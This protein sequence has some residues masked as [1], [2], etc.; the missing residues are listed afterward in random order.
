M[1][2]PIFNVVGNH[3]NEEQMPIIDKV[4]SL[5]S[6]H[7]MFNVDN[8]SST[9]EDPSY[10][11]FEDLDQC[12]DKAR[13]PELHSIARFIQSQSNPHKKQKLLGKFSDLKPIVFVRFNT[14][15]TGR[16]HPVTLKALLDSGGS[17]SL[18]TQQYA[19]KLKLKKSGQASTAWIT[20]AGSLTMTT[21]CKG[22][23][24]LLELH[25]NRLIEW[26]LHVTKTWRCMT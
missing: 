21:K 22:Q 4:P 3:Y 12:I 24:T 9:S 25:D 14:K 15:Q 18:V 7:E 13:E 2:G 23:F 20:P 10:Q 8:D 17:G 1:E 19:K 11:D 16:P 5:V 26:K 6:K